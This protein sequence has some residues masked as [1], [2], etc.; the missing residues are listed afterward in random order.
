MEPGPAIPTG[1]GAKSEQAQGAASPGHT[2]NATD[3]QEGRSGQLIP[4]D[5]VSVSGRSLSALADPQAPRGC[6]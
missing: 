3:V 1:V 4:A 5:V 2:P 6:V